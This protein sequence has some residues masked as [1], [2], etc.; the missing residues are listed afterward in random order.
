[1]KY[2]LTF[3]CKSPVCLPEQY[4][5]ILQAAILN[6]LGDGAY[7]SFLHDQGYQCEKR[8]FKLYTFSGIS[9]AHEYDGRG[10][11]IVFSDK[12]QFYL[13]FYTD[14][15]HAMILK[16]IEEKKSLR[17]GNQFL[18]LFD[19]ELVEERYVDCLVETVSPV[20]IHSTFEL[21][22]GRKKTYYYSPFER[23]FSEMIRQNLLR[24][25]EALY[26][27]AA[28]DDSFRIVPEKGQ[29]MKRVTIYYNRFVIQGWKGMFRLYGSEELIRM[30]LLSGIGARNGIG[31]GCVVQKKIV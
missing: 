15:S 3:L 16:N 6:W 30:A 31:F 4:N 29:K 21:A 2:R 25:Y 24:K 28:E 26:G 17:L 11:K 7:A 12:V 5:K 22:D 14:E 23:D 13:S 9:G 10:R 20:S 1:M 8:T 27:E 19:C 18:S